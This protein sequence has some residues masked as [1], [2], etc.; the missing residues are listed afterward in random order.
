MVLRDTRT[1]GT[2][3]EIYSED[4]DGETRTLIREVQCFYSTQE[5]LVPVEKFTVR[6]PM[7]EPPYFSD[8][9]STTVEK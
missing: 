4:A 3:R 1:R 5:L 6:M 9:K 2:S 8:E 7:V